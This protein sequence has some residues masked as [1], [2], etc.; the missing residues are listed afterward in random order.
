MSTVEQT[1]FTNK[2]KTILFDLPGITTPSGWRFFDNSTL[3]DARVCL[4]RF[5]FSKLRN[6]EP[7]G[8]RQGM[9]FG[10]CWH[11]AMD[12]VFLNAKNLD[13]EKLWVGA[14]GTFDAAW[15]KSPISQLEDF[16]LFPRT[17]GRAHDMLA[18]YIDRFAAEI[19]RCTVIGIEQ[20]FIVPLTSDDDKLMYIGKLDK[21]IETSEGI[22]IWDHKSA[23]SF[24]SSWLESF[25]PNSQIDG[26][27]HAGFTTYGSKFAGCM[28][29]GA[30]V[31]KTK[32]D[33]KRIP[34]SRIAAHLESWLFEVLETIEQIEYEEARLT[35]YR[36]S[37]KRD[38]I[39]K[40]FRQNTSR[41]TEY[42]GVCP[43]L[44]LCKFQ[45]NP[46]S[47]PIQ[48]ELFTEHKWQPFNIEELVTG[49]FKIE[50]KEGGE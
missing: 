4:R 46:D 34:I 40:C 29:D 37:G 11:S 25:S 5:Y 6:F 41:C 22:R 12:F 33:F 24:S 44:D 27:A 17:P 2:P 30:L 21:V 45:D 9:E 49:E 42:F 8:I 16:D 23:K 31:Q 1:D 18:E 3:T 39:L 48:D 15:Q 32:I 43:Y 7:K 35:E 26:Y 47:Y 13:N 28:I 20:P 38:T 19:K 14:C 50:I 36:M 10:T